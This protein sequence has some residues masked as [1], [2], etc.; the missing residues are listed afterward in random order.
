MT[1][2]NIIDSATY[3]RLLEQIEECIRQIN[4]YLLMNEMKFGNIVQ[5][6]LRTTT[7]YFTTSQLKHFREGK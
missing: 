2:S 6:V 7:R 4:Q 3:T 1:N 5:P